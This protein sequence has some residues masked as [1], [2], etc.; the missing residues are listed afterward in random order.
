MYPPNNLS[1]VYI[2]IPSNNL[3]LVYIWAQ[4]SYWIRGKKVFHSVAQPGGGGAGAIAL[5]PSACQP[6]CRIRKIPHFYLFWDHG[7]RSS[8][9][10]GGAPNF[11]PKND[12]MHWVLH[13]KSIGFS[14]QIKK[15]SQKK[16]KGLHWNWDGFSPLVCPHKTTICPNFWRFEPNGGATAPHPASYGYVWVCCL[17]WNGL[18]SDL[19][20]FWNVYSGGANLS[21]IKVTNQWKLR[22]MPKNK[23][24]NLI[25]NVKMPNISFINKYI[26]NSE[27]RGKGG[28][29]FSVS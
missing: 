7:R 18:K 1:M 3:T 24:S 23:Q 11:C 25:A 14:V 15:C 13:E 28:G 29:L 9:W 20:I 10:F 5:P 27:I 17:C 6:K 12:L 19:S 16:K 2:C 22:K 4:V 26:V 8:I 21:K